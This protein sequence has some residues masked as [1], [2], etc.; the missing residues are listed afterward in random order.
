MK[1][2]QTIL[3][4]AAWLC[5]MTTIEAS[6]LAAGFTVNEVLDYALDTSVAPLGSCSCESTKAGT[7]DCSFRAAIQASNACSDAA[8]T[9]TLSSTALPY[10]IDIAGSAEDAAA[11]GDLDVVRHPLTAHRGARRLP[12]T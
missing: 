7:G 3:V 2:K 6:A 5:S 4:V 1:F 8:D 12:S 10:R 9:I 11:T